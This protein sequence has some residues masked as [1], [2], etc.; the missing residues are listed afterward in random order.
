M[1]NRHLLGCVSSER[2]RAY[3]FGAPKG[4]YVRSAKG[5]ICSERRR[6]YM[7]GAPKGVYVRSAE[8][9][10]CSERRRAYM[11]GA[12][13]GVYV[14]SAKGALYDSQGQARSASPLVT[15][16]R[17]A[18]RPER[19]KLPDRITPF[20]GSHAFF[21]SYQGRRAPLRFAL[22]PGCHILRLWR[23]EKHGYSAPLAQRTRILCAFGAKKKTRIL[24]AFGAKQ[25]T[26]QRVRRR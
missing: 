4:V 10:I 11:F 23:K 16:T 21:I 19:P 17:S 14:R 13:K 22:A 5:R 9:R 18:S 8:G 12:P 15:N 6:A 7:F 24:C 20:Q 3:M 1:Q 2:Q 26:W 25:T